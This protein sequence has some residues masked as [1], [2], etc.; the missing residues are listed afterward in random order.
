MLVFWDC[1]TKYHKL[2]G[3]LGGLKKKKSSS[4]SPRGQK[5][6][7]QALAGLVPS[8]SLEGV[9]IPGLSARLW[10]FVGSLWLKD[11]SRQS[12][13]AFSHDVLTI[14]FHIIFPL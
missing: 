6:N 13:P 3:K 14:C 2:G 8:E 4:H 12:L 9:S 11:T 1:L 5:A 7:I 10:W